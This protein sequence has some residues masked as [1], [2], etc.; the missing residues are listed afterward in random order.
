[1]IGYKYCAIYTGE[2]SVESDYS[3]SLPL[4]PITRT[5]MMCSGLENALSECSFNGTN[6]NPDCDH[7]DDM[8]VICECK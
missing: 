4:I 7:S 3:F 1:M 2:A 8:L 6:G 5:N